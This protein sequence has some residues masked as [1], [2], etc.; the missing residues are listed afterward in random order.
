[1]KRILSIAL[2]ISLLF[3]MSACG[4]NPE[5]KNDSSSEPGSQPQDSSQ[6]VSDQSTTIYGIGDTW[7]V[8]GQWSL[9]ITSVT[10]TKDRNQ[11]S[12]KSPGAVYIVDYS[13]TNIGYTDNQDGIF[14]VMDDTIVDSAGVMGYSYP[15]DV[16]RYAQETP[17]GATCNAQVCIAVDNPGDFKL[18]V[19][20][21]DNNSE[22]QNATFEINVD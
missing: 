21:Y 15:G 17:V 13:Y 22:K 1:M 8:E 4:N 3:C 14:F 10:E 19:S 20:L 6:D 7:T 11:Y 18:I 2:S 5:S 16:E 9:T 12:E